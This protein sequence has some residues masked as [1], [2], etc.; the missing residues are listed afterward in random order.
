MAQLEG[1]SNCEEEAKGFKAAVKLVRPGWHKAVVVRSSRG[2]N[3]DKTGENLLLE[4]Q[5]IPS[6]DVV[7]EW[8]IVTHKEQKD[9]NRG[10][11]R[12]STIANLMGF[13]NISDSNQ[14]HGRPLEILVSLKPS[15]EINKKTG[16]P[17]DNNVI[18]DYRRVGS[19]GEIATEPQSG[20]EASAGDE[21][22]STPKKNNW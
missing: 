4:W 9:Q 20:E 19:A 14:L 11:A 3:K 2:P 7:K 12:I 15:N 5:V 17:F 21:A 1:F 18:D 16:K 13:P 10:R 22:P 8:I 6:G